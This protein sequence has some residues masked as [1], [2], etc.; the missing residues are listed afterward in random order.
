MENP[1]KI[2]AERNLVL[3]TSKDFETGKENIMPARWCTR[4]SNDPQLIAVSIGVT[5]YTHELLERNASFGISVPSDTFDY[6]FIGSHSGRHFDKFIEANIERVHGPVTGVP[7][8]ND[9]NLKIELGKYSSFKTGDHTFF[10]GKVL[11]LF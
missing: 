10:I 5:R 2:F 3:V 8:I 11:N 1:W 7:F 9:S 6:S 4:C